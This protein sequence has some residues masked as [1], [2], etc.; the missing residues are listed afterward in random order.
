[1]RQKIKPHCHPDRRHVN[2]KPKMDRAIIHLNVAD[3][4]VAVET[5]LQPALKGYPVVVAPLGAPRAVVYDMSDEAFLQGIRKGMPLA[6]AKRINRD[7]HVLPPCFIRYE[8][9]MKQL[10][11][12]GCQFTPQ[13]ESGRRD[14]HLFLDVTRSSRLFG[15]PVDMAFKLKKTF[16]RQF[17]LNPIWA[18]ATSKL[19][20]K[21]ATRVV[22]PVGEYIVFPGD[23]EAFLAPLPL[24][25]IPG[26]EKK[27]ITRL[28][29]FNLFH[30]SQARALTLEQLEIPFDRQASDVYKRIRG[31]DP[32]PVITAKQTGHCLAADHEFVNDTNHVTQLK[33]ALYHAIETICNP[34]RRQ[35]QHAHHARLILSYSDG[36]QSDSQCRLPTP[37]DCDMTLFKQCMGLLDKTWTRRV[38]VRHLRLICQ[39]QPARRIQTRLFEKPS[40]VVHQKKLMATMDRI[41]EKFGRQAIGPALSLVKEQASG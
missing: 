37:T 41:K 9:I 5:N 3:F 22:K 26:I 35:K 32:D 24:H 19:V 38:R 28:H 14:G 34:L 18:V 21:V 23:E 8:M 17:N 10:I 7:I 6:R 4:A 31:I 11:K 16:K 39:K 2:D 27:N 20:A 25:L 29:E 13:I 15:P 12:E 30:V 33:K 40:P 1:M 36:L